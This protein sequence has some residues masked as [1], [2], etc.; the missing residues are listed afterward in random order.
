[1]KTAVFPFPQPKENTTVTLPPIQQKIQRKRNGLPGRLKAGIVQ[2]MRRDDMDTDDMERLEE[3]LLLLDLNADPTNDIGG[4]MNCYYCVAAY[5]APGNINVS[6][7]VRRT[8][9]MQEAQ[10]AQ[11]IQAMEEI[12]SAA[13]VPGQFH[14][15]N[16]WTA[17][18]MAIHRL[19]PGRYALAF[20]RAAGPG[21]V[22][23]V[24][25]ERNAQGDGI[26]V[27]YFDAQ[28]NKAAN[29]SDTMNGVGFYLRY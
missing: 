12:F 25:V 17:V 7:L 5:L 11:S 15:F 13:G 3:Q 1:V 4:T 16:N 20:N 24:N 19:R 10:G 9:I 27:T 22:I 21:H 23:V 2:R 29:M 14:G 6:A 28:T 26:E 8:G 18:N